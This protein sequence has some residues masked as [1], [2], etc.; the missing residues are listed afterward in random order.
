MSPFFTPIEGPKFVISLPALLA[1]N[2]FLW[3]MSYLWFRYTQKNP[4]NLK[5]L[6]TLAVIQFIEY[7]VVVIWYYVVDYMAFPMPLFHCR[8]A[9]LL[10]IFL[11][12]VKMDP[13]YRAIYSY[14]VPLAFA[15]TIS[16]FIAPDPG[17][18]AVPHITQCGFYIG[19]FFLIIFAI[20]C[21][22]FD[23]KALSKEDFI[24]G[25][26]LVFGF[27][28]LIFFIARWSNMN[29]SYMLHPP[30]FKDLAK[31][32]PYVVYVAI[33]FLAYGLL[34]SVSFLLVQYL[35]KVFFHEH[36]TDLQEKRRTLRTGNTEKDKKLWLK[37]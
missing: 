25:Q 34:F 8:I 6:R 9:K 1:S 18:F 2:L 24:N 31:Q 5:I 15:G 27:N 7:I 26:K 37:N 30:I 14:A 21:L 35:Q 11:A 32:I 33:V 22:S 23:T 19:H 12:V 28:F 4:K 17:P 16:S 29:Y 20:A 36:L 10:L 3:V 13:K